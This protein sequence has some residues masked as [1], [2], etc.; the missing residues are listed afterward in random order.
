MKRA[1]NLIHYYTQNYVRYLAGRGKNGG[2]PSTMSVWAHYKLGRYCTVVDAVDACAELNDWR[3]QEALA[4]SASACNQAAMM[5]RAIEYIKA[6]RPS[7]QLRRRIAQSLAAFRPETALELLDQVRPSVLH[8]ALL[9]KNGQLEKAREVLEI[10]RR[11][12]PEW[13]SNDENGLLLRSKVLKMGAD[14]TLATI[15][16][17][18]KRFRIEEVQVSKVGDSPC[19]QNF[20]S[21]Q[22][23]RH[24]NGP[25]ISVIM[26]TYNGAGH[27]EA[28]ILSLLHQTYQRIE[29]IVIDDCSNDETADIIRH[30]QSK[31]SNI[32][33]KKLPVNVGPYVAKNLG[34]KLANGRFVTCHDSD[35]WSHPFKIAKQVEPLL[36]NRGLV[37]TASRWI[38]LDQNGYAYARSTYPFLRLNPSSI[39]F[40]KEEVMGRT[41]V[42]D[43]SRTGADSEFL[44]RLKVVFGRRRILT[45]DAP[46]AFGAHRQ[47]SLMTARSTGMDTGAIHP[48]RMAYW[49]AWSSWHINTLAN[50][51]RL[52]MPP[53]N[54][55]RPFPVPKNL[56]NPQESLCNCI[57]WWELD[58]EMTVRNAD[59]QGKA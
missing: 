25:L 11:K 45:L 6:S 5:E 32:V 37:A 51:E 42:W 15:N 26:T 41:G 19:P 57:Q 56:Q 31:H 38:R 43:W 40:R 33:Y 21:E 27:L 44:A 22:P 3:T 30:L 54:T 8:A 48:D 53:L 59:G 47:D 13:D 52:K 24:I 34:L 58:S 16:R 12:G 50:G 4:V 17:Y 36:K 20:H 18:L 55:N 7:N 14:E 39:M 1:K 2:E 35:D 28:A 29:L 46:L 23:N 49:Q 10:T 9:E